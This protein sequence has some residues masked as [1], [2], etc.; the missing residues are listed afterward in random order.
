MELGFLTAPYAAQPLNDTMADLRRKYDPSVLQ[1]LE[2]GT[3]NYPPDGHCKPIEYLGNAGKRQELKTLFKDHQFRLTA[4]SCHGN[5]LH[6]KAEIAKAHNGVTEQTIIVAGELEVPV[7]VLFSGLPGDGYSQIPVWV[8]NAWPDEHFDLYQKQLGEVAQYWDK[9]T[10]LADQAEV[11]LAIEL[12]PKMFMH[13][14]ATYNDVKTKVMELQQERDGSE[15]YK[16]LKANPDLSHFVWRGIDPV[17]AISA[18]GENIAYMHAK[19]AKVNRAQ[20]AVNGA[21]DARA[22]SNPNNRVWS[23][24]YVGSGDIVWKDV[25]RELQRVGYNGVLSIEHEDGERDAGESLDMA[26]N[27]LHA[28]LPRK[29]PGPMT[30]AA[31]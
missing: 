5:P 25:V 24:V 14:V 30:W 3:G 27:H 6:P 10:R 15:A 20:M 11:D 17:A 22:F 21:I 29:A 8:T 2:L 13:N 9:T 19:D 7:V 31:R 23:F 26:V 16:R 1:G 4:L 12:H 18:L 28:L